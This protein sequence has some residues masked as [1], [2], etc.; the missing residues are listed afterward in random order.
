MSVRSCRR[1]GF[2][3]F[4]S[5]FACCCFGLVYDRSFLHANGV[6]IVPGPYFIFFLFP[7]SVIPYCSF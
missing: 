6:V 7:Y 2:S 1:A 5:F 4:S 3:S